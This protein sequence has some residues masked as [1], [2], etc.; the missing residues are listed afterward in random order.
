MSLDRSLKTQG[1]L[2]RHRNVLKRDERLA[3]L[4]EDERWTDKELQFDDIA[5]IVHNKKKR[6]CPNHPA[7]RQEDQAPARTLSRQCRRFSCPRSRTLP[8]S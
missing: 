8:L 7:L 3:V 1:G 6:R 5:M 4:E 2:V